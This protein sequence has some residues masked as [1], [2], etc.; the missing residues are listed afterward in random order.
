ML[1][2]FLNLK[3]WRIISSLLFQKGHMLKI[4]AVVD[5]EDRVIFKIFYLGKLFAQSTFILA[6]YK[7]LHIL[8]NGSSRSQFIQY[9]VFQTLAGINNALEPLRCIANREL[10]TTWGFY[11][12]LSQIRNP[13][14]KSVT[15]KQRGFTVLP[16]CRVTTCKWVIPPEV[17]LFF[18]KVYFIFKF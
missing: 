6:Q 15:G 17:G 3:V 4:L 11:T 8:Q 16:G 9:N 7:I 2:Q 10:L 5:S 14:P 18:I 13:N 1:N 12:S